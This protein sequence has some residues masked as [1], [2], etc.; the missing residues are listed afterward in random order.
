[1]RKGLNASA[2]NESTGW[3]DEGQHTV[4]KA[5]DLVWIKGAPIWW[6]HS[7]NAATPN[8]P[9]GSSDKDFF[10]GTAVD[11]ATAAATTGVVN[12]NKEPAYIIDSTR[13]NGK[14]VIVKTVVGSTTVEVPQVYN[15]G[16]MIFAQFGT[17]AE[18]QKVDW[19][20][21]RGFAAGSNWTAWCAACIKRA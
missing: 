1:M 6:D 11:D 2:A 16:G 3:T 12:L 17:T 13:D 8:E 4:T 21:D 14:T 5:A 20:S 7:A 9:I 18:A 10:I 15:R 19:L